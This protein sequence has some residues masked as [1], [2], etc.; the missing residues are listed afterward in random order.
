MF[1]PFFITFV[2]LLSAS[3]PSFAAWFSASG[4]AIIVNGDKEQAR[5]E[6]TQ[7]AIRQALLFAGASVT[8][9]QQIANGLLLDEKLEIRASGEVSSVELVDEVYHD[10]F[11]TVSIRADIFAQDA[12]C[13][14]ADY[15]KKISTTYF[16]LR[17]E[18]QAAYG[19]IHHLGKEVAL[20]LQS[21]MNRFSTSLEVSHIEP[22]V[23]DWHKSDAPQ[24]AVFLANKSSTQYVL[25]A[26]IDDVSVKKAAG[27]AF[28]FYKGPQYTR[29][30]DITL[31]MINGATGKTVAKKTYRSIST[32]DFYST[33][34]IDVGSSEFWQSQYGQNALTTLRQAVAEL[35]ESALCE[36][37]MGRILAVSNTQAQINLGQSHKVQAG[38]EL[39]LFNVKQIADTF[40]QQYH[41]F[42]I[43]PRT[44]IV[45]QVFNN[46]A[47]VEAADN[48]LLGDV[49]TNDYVARR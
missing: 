37:T 27:S 49:Q 3:M 30:F 26:S 16:P 1:K 5:A 42:V 23:F 41:Q 25:T 33:Q 32:W 2:L 39:S 34:S 11:V 40:G 47:T 15:V 4:Q 31:T 20:K 6:A 13:S 22:Y 35:E 48:G 29:A 36:P 10:G 17:Y 45:R 8:S 38:D 19:Q 28:E 44:L 24:E 7:E 9:V 18:A 21:I 46:T 43:N 12:Q 14:A